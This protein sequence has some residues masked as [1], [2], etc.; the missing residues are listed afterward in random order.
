MS[1]EKAADI[2]FKNIP[3]NFWPDRV[4]REVLMY[5]RARA[6][7]EE[8]K[9]AELQAQETQDLIDSVL[10][11]EEKLSEKLE[12]A[13]EGIKALHEQLD[14]EKMD[15]QKQKAAELGKLGFKT[16]SNN[17]QSLLD[18]EQTKKVEEALGPFAED[19]EY[20]TS[21]FGVLIKGAQAI[22][23]GVDLKKGKDE[24][25]VQKKLL[26]FKRN[27]AIYQLV[28][29]LIGAGLGLDEIIP[30]LKI[31]SKGKV[32]A[33]E[34]IKACTY[35]IKLL[36]IAD[37]KDDAKMDPETM[38]ALPLARMARNQK[39]RCSKSTV[40]VIVAAV[41]LAGAVGEM[42]GI[43]AHAG[44]A[45]DATG[46]V[47]ELGGK[48]VFKG[49]DWADARRCVKTMKKAAGPPPNRKAMTM[50]FKN[51]TRY[52][53]YA[54]AYGAVEGND[55][56]AVQYLVNAKL[57]EADLKSPA[58][59][60]EI[61]REYMLITAGGIMGE[62]DK[63]EDDPTI[64]P[65]QKKKGLKDKAK[66]KVKSV[67]IAGAKKTRDKIIG[68]D[69]SKPYDA[70][71]KAPAAALTRAN[72][73]QTVKTGALAAGWYDTRSG[74]GDVLGEYELAAADFEKTPSTDTVCAVDAALDEVTSAITQIGT[75]A[76]DQKTPHQGMIDFIDAL[77]EKAEKEEERIRPL[78]QKLYDEQNSGDLQGDELGKAKQEK[79]DKDLEAA[80]E[81]QAKKTAV[82]LAYVQAFWN[83][84]KHPTPYGNL[85]LPDFCIKASE[86]LELDQEEELALCGSIKSINDECCN[87]LRDLISAVPSPNPNEKSEGPSRLQTE[88][89]RQATQLEK[90]LVE[91]LRTLAQSHYEAM[92]QRVGID[93]EEGDAED[94]GSK[95]VS[96]NFMLSEKGWEAAKK[97]ATKHGL[98]NKST[99][100]GKALNVFEKAQSE[101][102]KNHADE[103]NVRMV[104][105]SLNNVTKAFEKFKPLNHKRFPHRGMS[106]YRSKMM[107]KISEYEK[108]FQK[109]RDR[110]KESS[111]E[112]KVEDEKKRAEKREANKIDYKATPFTKAAWKGILEKGLKDGLKKKSNGLPKAF[113]IYEKALAKYENE[114]D[115]VKENGKRSEDTYMKA[116][117]NL[118]DTLAK[119]EPK[120]SDKSD[121]DGL[122]LSGEAK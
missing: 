17:A 54:L 88:L 60:I 3:K 37:L 115:P 51:S 111:N 65:G 64:L 35:M 90:S 96:P 104:I 89:T 46:K 70:S 30:A 109:E 47:L 72:F 40:A 5:R 2:A 9:R 44:L 48:A 41:Q 106:A 118:N 24:G 62:E 39:I 12:T 112:Q 77:Y 85:T 26:E 52:A 50:I 22:K 81:K 38:M 11:T 33:E 27:K 16:L 105:G 13:S 108:A 76:N 86:T 83:K 56:W 34:A 1:P 87:Q 102:Q 94:D 49:I 103:K 43:G 14:P 23:A 15:E 28:D 19:F 53:T 20:A 31:A 55:P 18:S 21:A 113:K 91:D 68:R 73:W 95:W 45:L 63:E 42:S 97:D 29:K 61:V 84:R 120:M 67:A 75:L 116:I 119:F 107:L 80:K 117:L 74:I 92:K 10:D 110:K 114:T 57:T 66:D 78:R 7:F 71:W 25:P 82:R 93:E 36:E 121:H 98:V 8:E 32:V 101:Y 58:T 122:M 99:G 4:V 69:T 6:A 79:L 59:S 100:I